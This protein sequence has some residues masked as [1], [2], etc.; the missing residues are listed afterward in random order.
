MATNQSTNTPATGNNKSSNRPLFIGVGLI[1]LAIIALFGRSWFGMGGTKTETISQELGTAK[2]AEI[3]LTSGINVLHVSEGPSD[4]LIA[5]KVETSSRERLERTFEMKGDTGVFRL[6]SKGTTNFFPWFSNNTGRDWDV[7]LS[8]EIPLALT[9]KS[10]VGE[11]HLDLSKLM[12]TDLELSTGVGKTTVDL[13]VTGQIKASIEVGVGETTIHIPEGMAA[14]IEATAGLGNVK[15]S[16]NFGRNGD[17][18]VSSDYD[19]ATNRIDLKVTGGI[20]QVTVETS[21]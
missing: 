5:G 1:L 14:R 20:G 19:T 11:V 9:L 3:F 4:T 10:G 18:Y 17:D 6:E 7:Q 2:Q 8:P 15:V 21:Q 12:V 16:E 13:P